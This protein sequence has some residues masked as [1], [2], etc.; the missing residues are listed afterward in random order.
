MPVN[1]HV[2]SEVVCWT[3]YSLRLEWPFM[4]CF[5]SVLKCG[6]LALLYIMSLDLFSVFF[7]N[8]HRERSFKSKAWPMLL[9]DH[10]A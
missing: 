2:N 10:P 8:L 4:K 6:Y 1:A 7:I 9:G 5:G 3:G